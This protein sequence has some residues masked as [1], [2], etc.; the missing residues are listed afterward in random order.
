MFLFSQTTV[1]V[2]EDQGHLNRHKTT[3]FSVIPSLKELSLYMPKSEPVQKLFYSFL[4]FFFSTKSPKLGVSVSAAYHSIQM[5]LQL[6]EI[7]GAKVLA[8]LHHN[9]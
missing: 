3:Q 9:V 4:L 7:N 1:T 5:H 8:F 6:C 2:N